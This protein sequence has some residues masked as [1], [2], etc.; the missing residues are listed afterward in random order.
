MDTYVSIVLTTIFGDA[1]SLREM[2]SKLLF[3]PLN[4]QL[5]IKTAHITDLL[6][7]CRTVI[8]DITVIMHEELYSS[9]ITV[10]TKVSN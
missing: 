2:K 5:I 9:M 10:D 3:K 4:I 1:L 6:C 7:R 8:E